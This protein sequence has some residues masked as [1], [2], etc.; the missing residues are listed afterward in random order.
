MFWKNKHKLK[1][2]A[3]VHIDLYLVVFDIVIF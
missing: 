3:Y 2:E 1:T